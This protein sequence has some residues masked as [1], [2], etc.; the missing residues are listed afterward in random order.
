MIQDQSAQ[1]FDKN[2]VRDA[3]NN[4]FFRQHEYDWFGQDTWKV[5]R[6]LTL[7]LGL[8]YQLNGV[9]Y[10]E[11][12]NVSNLL[13]DPASFPVVFSIVGPG[14]GKSLYRADYSNIEPRV[15]F[16]W[17]PWSDGK[18][19]I[20]AAFGIFHDRIFGDIF[21]RVGGLPP[22]EQDYFNNPLDTIGN[23]LN[24][25]LGTGGFPA[26]P[27]PQTPSASVPDGKGL[28][29]TTILDTHLRNPVANNWNFG[30]QR[31]LPGGNTLDVTYVGSLGVHVWSNRD[32]NPP[33]P[34]LVQQ[35]LAFCVPTNPQNTG[36]STPSGQC[37]ES[38]VTLGSL[39]QG[40]DAFF[41]LPFNAV[42]HNAL[43]QPAY[44]QTVYNSIYHGLQ[45]K[46]T[47]RFSHGLQLQGAYT[48][49]HAIDNSVDPFLP[50]VGGH[51]FPRNSLNLAQSRGNSDNDTRHVGVV[52]YI[53]EVPL[54][55][56]KSYLNTGVLGKVFEGIQFSGITTLQSGH[57][58]QVRT[59]QD[60][61]HTG[62]GAWG[63]QVG[64]PYAA[65]AS[66]ACAPNPSLGKVYVT[67]TCAFVEPPFGSAG[68]GRNQFYGPGFWNF[69]L[70]ISKRMKLSERFEL[71][72]RFEGY[73]IF[74]HPHFVNP[75]NPDDNGNLIESS[76]FGVITNTYTQP[77][78]TTSARQIQV[79]MKLNF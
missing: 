36:F 31:E 43:V 18:T 23:A 13:T 65:P 79:A 26:I 7:T 53:W 42:P 29:L 41:D 52:S 68:S 17:D 4:K 56:G 34:A 75:G 27:P 40:A 15:G 57:P 51:T 37:D 58:F 59:L 20:R 60:S 71:E 32:G 12:S 63:A 45:S 8:R 47:H 35:L 16:S 3:T 46:F 21:T 11:N 44:Q 38:T 22:F 39:Y 30:I 76:L 28:A 72:T 5:R 48:Y 77:D 2:Q 50:G 67:N 54:G 62:V 9:P 10:E 1:F 6:N 61:Q 78:G 66:P 14:T 55:K 19:A 64:D 24:D 25:P 49:S 70:S 33:Q 69:D 73:N 74:N